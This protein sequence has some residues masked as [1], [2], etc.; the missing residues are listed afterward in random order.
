MRNYR[1]VEIYH[2]LINDG[3]VSVKDFA[4]ENGVSVRTVQRDINDLKT[5]LLDNNSEYEIIYLNEKKAYK[6]SKIR[7]SRLTKGQVLA[8]S[9]IILDSRAFCKK[10]IK[11]IL[12]NFIR[13]CSPETDVAIISELVKNEIFHYLELQHHKNVNKTDLF[14]DI[15]ILGKAIK[16][17]KQ[18]KISYKRESKV[19]ERIVDPVGLMFSEYYFYLLANITDEDVKETFNIKNDPYPTIYRVDRIKKIEV[20]NKKVRIDYKDRFQEGE[21]RKRIHF[22]TSGELRKVKFWYRGKNLEAVLDKI[23]TAKIE[24]EA[25]NSN[26]KEYLISAE[27]FGNGIDRYLRS[28]GEEIEN[29]RKEF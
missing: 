6:L 18:I 7:N 5:F 3:E 28:L 13:F 10:D 1:I 15:W 12:E 21:F 20:T 23:P 17:R 19:V 25:T 8:I 14:N 27:V 11:H 26:G 22:M 9:K 24:K 29:I 16:D 4:D 2:K